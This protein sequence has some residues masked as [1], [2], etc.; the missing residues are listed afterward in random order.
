MK[1][2]FNS[3]P[4]FVG[5]ISLIISIL[6]VGSFLMLKSNTALIFLVL[7]CL[8]F[9]TLC[10]FIVVNLVKKK[11]TKLV[12]LVFAC[13][14]M[15]IGGIS[16]LILV[17]PQNK[18]LTG[19]QHIIGVVSDISNYSSSSVIELDKVKINNVELGCKISLN[20]YTYGDLN[21]A[22]GETVKILT[23]LVFVNKTYDNVFYISENVGYTANCSINDIKVVNNNS[24]HSLRFVITNLVKQNLDKFLNETN[25]AI[26]YS[27]LFGEKDGMPTETYNMFSYAGIAHVLAVS[28]LHIGFLVSV[29]SLVLKVLKCNKNIKNILL[30]SLLLFYA[31]LCNF[32]ASV[33]RAVI[34]SIVLLLS[35]SYAKEYDSL[36]SLS[37][38]ATIILLFSPFSIFAKGFQLSFMAVF[39]IITLSKPIEDVLAKIKCPEKLSETISMSLTV[40]LGLLC[41]SAQHF[42][43]INLIS[44]FSNIIVIPIFSSC[45]CLMFLT[46]FLGLLL[47]FVNYLLVVPNMLLHF[48]KLIANLF[49]NITVLNFDLFK[50][51]YLFVGLFVLFAYIF[52]FALVPKNIKRIVCSAIILTITIGAFVVNAPAK[53]DYNLALTS[54]TMQG[55][56]VL[57][58]NKN[59][60]L[61]LVVNGVTNGNNIIDVLNNSNIAKINS[62]VV[63]NY[64]VNQNE[65][66]TEL[67]EKYNVKHMYVSNFYGD[68]LQES[69]GDKTKINVVNNNFNCGGAQIEILE[70]FKQDNFAIKITFEGNTFLMI[71]TNAEDAELNN[72]FLKENNFDFVVANNFSGLKNGFDFT[73]EN[74]IDDNSVQ[75]LQGKNLFELS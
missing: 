70:G 3:R 9:I 75:I 37:L 31:Y 43:Q 65:M 29:L 22:E 32:T 61:C 52:H 74:L 48:I 56:Y 36:N 28:G 7:L 53:I 20:C 45:F 30:V 21:L 57:V 5:A 50:F 59:D 12:S 60:N 68:L 17:V 15:L 2:L 63:N 19:E 23:D 4:I 35:K 38:A 40:N 47:P 66:L 69:F 10:S 54:K 1:K 24:K 6:T 42:N 34:M 72:Y 62:I 44:I 46:C 51:S 64:A 13:V 26:A 55:N 71:N 33:T 16:C 14:Y 18:E 25:S 49:A 73:C 41:I 11:Y 27:A 58:G 67:I 8:V 39:S